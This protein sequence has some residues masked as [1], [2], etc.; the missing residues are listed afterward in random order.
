MVVGKFNNSF[1][2]SRSTRNCWCDWAIFSDKK[3]SYT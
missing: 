1:R 2:W 3:V